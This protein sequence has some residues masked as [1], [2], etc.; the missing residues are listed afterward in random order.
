M[1]TE[2]E[3]NRNS[4][5][6]IQ[7]CRSGPKSE[8][9]QKSNKTTIW[10][11]RQGTRDAGDDTKA[12]TK[13]RTGTRN[14]TRNS[15]C[16]TPTGKMRPAHDP[17]TNDQGWSKE[18]I[19]G[20]GTV[21][22]YTGTD[23]QGHRGGERKARATKRVYDGVTNVARCRWMCRVKWGKWSLTWTVRRR[24]DG[25]EDEPGEYPVVQRGSPDVEKKKSRNFV[26]SNKTTIWIPRQG[27]RD[28]GD[29]TK[30]KT[31]RTTPLHRC[32]HGPEWWILH[33]GNY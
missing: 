18:G 28:A 7:C 26:V 6:L 29:D 10:I 24:V 19:S 23:E 12:K 2:K 11:P 20:C 27:T 13:G 4:G 1:Y 17:C 31:K 25:S 22:G 32:S 30:A 15:G 5:G 3:F 21:L 14:G 16:A 33:T 8:S 9:H